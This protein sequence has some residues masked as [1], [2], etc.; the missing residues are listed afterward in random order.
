MSLGT[1]LRGIFAAPKTAPNPVNE[2]RLIYI[3]QTSAGLR[4]TAEEAL[5]VPAVWA[6]VSVISKALASC[7]WDV[8]RESADGKR[9]KM[10]RHPLVRLLNGEPNAEMTGFDFRE[11][12]IIQALLWGDGFAEIERDQS[13]QAIGLWPFSPERAELD[14]D[15]DDRLI[16]RVHNTAGGQSI[17]DYRD[18]FHVHGPSVDG[19]T[20]LRTYAYAR[21]T[22]GIAIAL[23]RFGGAF[24]KNNM[25]LGGILSTDQ[26][27][28]KEQIDD[29]QKALAS[30][31][32]GPDNAHKFLVLHGGLKYEALASTQEEAQTVESRHAVIEDVCRWFGVPPHKIAHLLRSTNNNIE[33]QGLEF[34]RDA[35][36]PW[37]ERLRQEADKK[38]I[39][40]PSNLRT[41]LD[42]DWLAEGDAK[43]KAD[44]DAVLVDH[45]I[46]TR[47]EV[48]RRR[49][50]NPHEDGDDL[51]VQQQFI[52]LSRLGEHLDDSG[53]DEEPAPEPVV[54]LRR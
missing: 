34:V 38:L 43:S 49:G 42:L 40:Q 28:Q 25:Q 6:C 35:L 44:A 8:L 10:P 24:Y 27:L 29:L 7:D 50:R 11:A 4:V 54:R 1:W 15:P 16:V 14:R 22:F 51:T 37:A 5:R 47:N 36:T 23:D 19:I 21:D 33:H 45:G 17:L 31:H 30:R 2:H 46:E 18:V 9:E 52:P 32:G 53:A 13:G 20:G 48:R 41:R 26:S 3:P 39:R 12:M